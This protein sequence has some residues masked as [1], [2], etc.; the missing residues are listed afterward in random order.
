MGKPHCDNTHRES[1]Y[2]ETNGDILMK[3]SNSI[4][5]DRKLNSSEYSEPNLPNNSDFY[6][7]RS[8]PEDLGQIIKNQK[9]FNLPNIRNKQERN[10]I[11]HPSVTAVSRNELNSFETQNPQ[12]LSR[13]SKWFFSSGRYALLANGI[14]RLQLGS[15]RETELEFWSPQAEFPREVQQ[16][17]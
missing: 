6:Y 3:S 16:K 7:R 12:S 1:F 14:I 11:G 9:S 17:R 8:K 13:G 2:L 4:R 10:L 5:P 15:D